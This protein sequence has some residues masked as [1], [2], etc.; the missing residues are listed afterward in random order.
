[1]YKKLAVFDFDGTITTKDT[2]W[3]FLKFSK[4]SFCFYLALIKN[5]PSIILA[6]LRLYPRGRAKEKLF[7]SC[8]KGMIRPEFEKLC[9][10]FY[11]EHKS[12]IKPEAKVAVRNHLT[13]GNSVVILT[14]SPVNWVEPFAHSLGI[15]KV[16]G[17]EL[18]TDI[19]GRLTGRFSTLNCNGP[20]KVRRLKNEYPDLIRKFKIYAYGDSF[21]DKE[22]LELSDYPF[23]RRF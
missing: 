23:F 14:A 6:A 1:M 4:G 13:H 12:I 15:T 10:S 9:H 8:F 22:L 19:D 16:I 17:T 7:S 3:L 2:L 21:G 18:E 20:E 5:S 11:E